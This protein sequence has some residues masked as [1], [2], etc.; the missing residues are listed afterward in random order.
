MMKKLLT[1]TLFGLSLLSTH[2]LA[3]TYQQQFNDLFA[4]SDTIGQRQLLAKWE[5][6]SKNDP[7]LF[8]AYF[9][10]YVIKSKNEIIALGQNPKGKEFLEISSQDTT[11]KDPMGYLYG[12]TQYDPVLLRKGFNWINRGIENHPNRL[13]MRFG[14]IYIYG[15][16]EDYD[17]FT[18]EIIK[19]VHWKYH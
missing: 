14:K 16:T 17:N 7:E 4:K 2:G 5:K 3:Q 12:D 18:N 6:A 8:V 19:T 9:N 13:D 15:Q 1:F 11:Q 10:Y